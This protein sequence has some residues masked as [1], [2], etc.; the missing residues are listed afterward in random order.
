MLLSHVLW[1]LDVSIKLM[2]YSI[3][4]RLDLGEVKLTTVKLL[5]ADKSYIFPRT[6]NENVLVS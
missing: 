6:E 2:S 5:M 4:K 3:D 1:D